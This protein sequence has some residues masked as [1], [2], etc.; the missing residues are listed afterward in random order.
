MP[1]AAR[2]GMDIWYETF[3]DSADPPLLLVMGLG[4]Q[5]ISWPDEFCQGFV[6]RGFFVIRFDNRDVGLSGRAS[7]TPDPFAVMAA[8]AQGERVDAPYLLTDMAD[9][10]FALL[11]ALGIGAAHV[12]GAS[13]GGMIAQTMAIT[14]PERVLTLTSIMSTTGQPDVGQA[15]PE[16]LSVLL[17]PPAADREAVIEQAVRRVK[18]IG[19]PDQL[20]ETRVREA[21]GA[22][23]DRAF[24]PNG[25]VRQLTAVLAS[26]SRAEGLASVTVPT[27]VIH[28]SAD[29]LV[30][31][32]G[33][34]RTAELVAGA[35]LELIEGMGH[36][37]PV[38]FWSRIIE[39]VT[40]H[41][42][43]AASTR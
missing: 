40:R 29:R 1:I 5:A 18:A 17:E 37:L 39:V 31:P 6:D 3:G 34:Q 24:D 21:A 32:S 20:D 35:Q 10:A 11:D 33:G 28:G 42:A 25:V 30:N 19:S 43:Q 7:G 41:A 14:H 26:G 23:Y 22:A 12:A 8:A 27:L 16:V 15:D 4:G 36:D 13:M 9:D 38:V 2:T